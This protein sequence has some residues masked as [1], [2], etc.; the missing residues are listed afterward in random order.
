M[1]E[2]CLENGLRGSGEH[3]FSVLGTPLC[4][5]AEGHFAPAKF[6]LGT[7]DV[8]IVIKRRKSVE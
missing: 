8:N 2:N 3:S 6:E 1:I 5:R 4:Q 7:Y